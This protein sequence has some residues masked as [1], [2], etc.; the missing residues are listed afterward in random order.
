MILLLVWILAL[1]L[2]IAALRMDSQHYTRSHAGWLIVTVISAVGF[3]VLGI[4][5]G[6]VMAAQWMSA[7]WVM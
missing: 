2:S 3:W 6:L 1:V 5:M 4:V 7:Y